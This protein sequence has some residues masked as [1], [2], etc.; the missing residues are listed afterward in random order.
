MNTDHSELALDADGIPILT[1]LVSGD[2]LEGVPAGAT[3]VPPS[4]KDITSELL[5]SESVSQR[6]DRIA[7]SLARDMRLHIEQTLAVAIDDAINRALD[8]NNTRTHD[9]IRHQL[10]VALAEIITAALQDDDPIF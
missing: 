7:D 10:D 6:L 1:D 5:A 3:V 8:K 9:S 2:G 4:P